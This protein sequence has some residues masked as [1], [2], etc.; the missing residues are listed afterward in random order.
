MRPAAYRG[1]LELKSPRQTLERWVEIHSRISTSAGPIPPGTG[2]SSI[3]PRDS[4]LER[5]HVQQFGRPELGVL[6][7]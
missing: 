6:G 3:S 5:A 4:H 1:A 2:L 7:P